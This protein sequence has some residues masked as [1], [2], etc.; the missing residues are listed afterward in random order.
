MNQNKIIEFIEKL[1]LNKNINFDIVSKDNLLLTKSII[2]KA[3]Y[4]PIN[5][6]NYIVKK[7]EDIINK[8]YNT[9]LNFDTTKY[10]LIATENISYDLI[11]KELYNFP[12]YDENKADDFKNKIN[13]IKNKYIYKLLIDDIQINVFFYAEYDQAIFNR[14][15]GIIYLFIKTFGIDLSIYDNYNIRFLLVDFPRRLDGKNKKSKDSF[16]NLGLIGYFNN[17]SGVHIKNKKELVVTRKSGLYGLLIHELIHMV[18]LDFCFN[19]TDGN[20]ANIMGWNK[21]WVNNN[22]IVQNDNNIVS[23][24]ESICN[25]NSSYFVS[26]YNAIILSKETS[27]PTK[28]IKYFK[29]F[30]YLETVYCYIQGIKLLNYFNFNTYESFFNNTSNR[31][32]YQNAYVF[33]YVI[34]RMFLISDYY[35]L[36]LKPLQDVNYN[37]KTSFD[38]NIKFQKSLNNKLLRMVSENSLKKI[39][40]NIS[41]I[42]ED[43]DNNYIEYFLINI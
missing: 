12:S 5:D 28:L 13:K 40:D 42:F 38:S 32:Y 20:M 25:T 22:N 24:I 35:K 33:E 3:D 23:F 1:M 21:E 6:M 36:L 15:L 2:K 17:S 27:N 19:K 7:S 29:Y 39:Y 4:I 30:F 11:R 41:N 37:K 31:E 10:E 9:Y 16:R 18:G 34:M 8:L 14:L 26:I 43:N